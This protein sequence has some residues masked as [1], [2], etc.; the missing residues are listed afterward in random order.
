MQNKCAMNDTN[1]HH[2]NTNFDILFGIKYYKK[3]TAK[4]SHL[5]NLYMN[6]QREIT[7]TAYMWNNAQLKS[8]ALILFR[9]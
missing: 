2:E 1:I 6:K 8:S 9:H 7:W 4:R 3:I 5:N